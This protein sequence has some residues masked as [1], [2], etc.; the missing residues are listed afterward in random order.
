MEATTENIPVGFLLKV[1]LS[2]NLYFF[3]IFHT[4]YYAI[5]KLLSKTRTLEILS[6][7]TEHLI[8][9]FLHTC[10]TVVINYTQSF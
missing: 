7:F 6:N 9:L 5:K 1:F 10:N 4:D 3:S 8:E 2:C